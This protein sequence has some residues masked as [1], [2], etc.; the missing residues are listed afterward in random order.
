MAIDR[1]TALH[2]APV[3]ISKESEQF[4]EWQ[5]AEVEKMYNAKYVIDSSQGII[6]M[7][8]FYTE[9]PHPE[10]SNYFKL[11]YVEGQLR[12]A[13]GDD[14]ENYVF[15]A[16]EDNGFLYHSRSR[17]DYRIAG[18]GFIDGGRAYTRSSGSNLKQFIIRNG[19]AYEA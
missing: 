19:E 1:E 12:I 18:D 11:Y 15:D 6:A 8:Y 3:L 17:H 10:G 7:S 14:I 16:I 5:I 9:E 13:N 2:L 4:K